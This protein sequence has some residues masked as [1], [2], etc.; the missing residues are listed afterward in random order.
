MDDSESDTD[1]HSKCNLL[2]Q[3]RIITIII[4]TASLSLLSI[5]ILFPFV[6]KPAFSNFSMDFHE[7]RCYTEKKIIRSDDDK[8]SWISCQDSCLVNPS[9]CLQ[10]YVNYKVNEKLT[11]SE[12]EEEEN[13]REKRNGNEFDDA[14]YTWTDDEFIDSESDYPSE[15]SESSSD[16]SDFFYRGAKLFQNVRGCG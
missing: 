6:I 1:S 3:K 4:I 13:H 9:Q 14:D 16:T 15:S 12:E 11:S 10:I 8:C 2:T 7:A 5:L